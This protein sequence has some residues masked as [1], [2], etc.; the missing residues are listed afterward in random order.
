[1]WVFQLIK[2]K[3]IY[4]VLANIDSKKNFFSLRLRGHNC[5]ISQISL[6]S[7]DIFTKKE[8]TAILFYFC[9]FFYLKRDNLEAVSLACINNFVNKN[10]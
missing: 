8:K 9:F 4:L 10:A 1:M 6:I 5:D 3:P 7:T 2:N